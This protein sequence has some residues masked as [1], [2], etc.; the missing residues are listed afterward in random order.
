MSVGRRIAHQ[1]IGAQKNAVVSEDWADFK[2]GQHVMTID[3]FPGHVASIE[4]GPFPGTEAYRV[5]LDG[6]LGGGLYSTSQLSAMPTTTAAG[7]HSA[8]TDYPELSEIL[9][10]RPDIA[11]EF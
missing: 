11:G 9:A 4:D 7:E 2:V 8:A 10:R 3:G 5:T 6:D 1:T